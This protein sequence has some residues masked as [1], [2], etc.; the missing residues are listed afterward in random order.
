MS[1]CPIALP[2]A[3][4]APAPARVAAPLEGRMEERQRYETRLEMLREQVR[5]LGG[6]P[7]T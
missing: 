7:V 2:A 1:G 3:W 5:R 4:V 6:R